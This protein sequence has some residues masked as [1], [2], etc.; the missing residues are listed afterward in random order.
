MPDRAAERAARYVMSRYSVLDD[1]QASERKQLTDE[2]ESFYLPLV[3]AAR[4]VESQ[5]RAWHAMA[6]AEKLRKA[7]KEV[8]SA[9]A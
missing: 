1:M 8:T 7:L 3:E 9:D 5:L 6:Q 4:E 2:I